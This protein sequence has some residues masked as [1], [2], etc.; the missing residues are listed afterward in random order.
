MSV[1]E[2]EKKEGEKRERIGYRKEKRE[3]EEGERKKSEYLNVVR[4]RI[5]ENIKR[6]KKYER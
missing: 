6:N 1:D 5:K 2:I 3:K 4:R